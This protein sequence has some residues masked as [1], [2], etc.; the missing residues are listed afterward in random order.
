MDGGLVEGFNPLV[1]SWKALLGLVF[2][3][4]PHFSILDWAA[5]SSVHSDPRFLS[6]LELDGTEIHE[7]RMPVRRVVDALDMVGQLCVGL[8]SAVFASET[9]TR[10]TRVSE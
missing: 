4:R 1:V 5:T 10:G 3:R 9:Q 6:L 2:H 8:P 7:P